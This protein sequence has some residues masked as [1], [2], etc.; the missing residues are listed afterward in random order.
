MDYSKLL[1]PIIRRVMPDIIARELVEV[2]PMGWSKEDV[3]KR[4][5]ALEAL[6]LEGENP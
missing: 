6:A 2:Q 3:W 1:I 5:L 4:C